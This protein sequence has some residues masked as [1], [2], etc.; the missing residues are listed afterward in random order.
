VIVN[1]TGSKSGLTANVPSPPPAVERAGASR[2]ATGTA[3]GAW[4]R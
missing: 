1:V 4:S 2:G 3:A